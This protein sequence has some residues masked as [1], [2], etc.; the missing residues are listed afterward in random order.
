MSTLETIKNKLINQDVPAL[1]QLWATVMFR[2]VGWDGLIVGFDSHVRDLTR[3]KV[4]SAFKLSCGKPI[5]KYR[6]IVKADAGRV[7]FTWKDGVKPADWLKI[8]R[9]LL[10]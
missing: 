8:E 3:V 9:D 10:V 2:P 6:L 7:Q 4:G 5:Q 1:N